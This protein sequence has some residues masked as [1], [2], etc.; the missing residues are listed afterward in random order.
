MMTESLAAESELDKVIES[1][2]IVK[3]SNL[4]GSK[5]SVIGIQSPCRLK[6]AKSL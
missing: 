6:C 5:D 1:L 3:Q 2:P 4:V